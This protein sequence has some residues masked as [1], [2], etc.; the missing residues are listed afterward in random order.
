MSDPFGPP[1]GANAI[2]DPRLNEVVPFE[3]ADGIMSLS[4]PRRSRRTAL[5]SVVFSVVSCAQSQPATSEAEIVTDRPDV[6]ESSIVVPKGSLQIENGTMWTSNHGSQTFDLSES[7]IRFGLALARNSGS[8]R[9][10]TFSEFQGPVRPD[11]ATSR[12]E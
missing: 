11:L 5:I 6:T 3:E 4:A 10:T 7:L 1:L 9:Q 8:L 12:W 2:S